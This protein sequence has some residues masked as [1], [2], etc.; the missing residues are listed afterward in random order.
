MQGGGYQYRLCP[1]EQFDAL[2]DSGSFRPLEDC[3]QQTPMPFAGDSSMMMSNG[4]MLNLTSVFVTEG[5]KPEGSAW[6]MLPIPNVRNWFPLPG[7]RAFA[8][9]IP[10]PCY[11]PTPP[12]SLDQ[13]ICTGE[14]MTN[15][16]LYDRLRVPS[17][18][19]A[20]E[21]VLGF[22]WDCEASAQIW[23]QCADVTIATN[24]DPK[25]P[26]PPAPDARVYKCHQ[27]QCI[28]GDEAAGALNKTEC[29]MMCKPATYICDGGKCIEGMSG[30]LDRQQC[31]AACS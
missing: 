28:L 23:Q 5:T 25:P 27:G 22:R 2:K 9:Q 10:V 3:F 24:P 16:T 15:I 21:Y 26:T 31:E 12:S 8:Y 29:G 18:L 4:T 1:L 19:P 17:H 11:D 6:Q 20:G 13:G 7:E 14:W 30:G